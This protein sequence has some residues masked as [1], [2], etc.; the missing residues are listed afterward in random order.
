MG[1]TEEPP[2]RYDGSVC[3]MAGTAALCLGP[4]E[5]E[6]LPDLMGGIHSVGVAPDP[7]DFPG[8]RAQGRTHA[9]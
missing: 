5:R 9:P 3:G 2:R 4:D 1:A 8:A 6:T 7:V